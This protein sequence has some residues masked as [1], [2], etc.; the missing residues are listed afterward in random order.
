MTA[1]ATDLTVHLV[2]PEPVLTLCPALAPNAPQDHP[3]DLVL[4]LAAEQRARVLSIVDTVIDISSGDTAIS[5][6]VTKLADAMTVIVRAAASVGL[7]TV[8]FDPQGRLFGGIWEAVTGDT[9]HVI[10]LIDCAITHPGGPEA[11]ALTAY[12][13]EVYRYA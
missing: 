8:P 10:N 11:D 2:A 1:L 4:A 13:P 6:E 7:A 5:A 3:L 12:S 9:D